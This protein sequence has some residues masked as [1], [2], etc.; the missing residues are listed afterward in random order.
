M[1]ANDAAE[2][3]MSKKEFQF[4]KDNRKYVR[5]KVTRSHN[6]IKANIASCNTDEC[7]VVTE[8][9]NSLRV[10]LNDLNDKV[11]RGLWVGEADRGALDA[12][13]DT[14]DFYDTEIAKA[15]RL[16]NNR[17]CELNPVAAPLSP[18]IIGAPGPNIANQIK[19]PQ[20]PMPEYGN[21]E[22]E[23]LSNFFSNFENVINKY[24][25]SEFEKFVFLS[26][27]LSGHPLTI[28]KSLQSSQQSYTEA[29]NLL[30]KAFEC[31]HNQ[32]YEIIHRLAKIKLEDSGDP[33]SFVSELKIINQ[34]F[35]SLQISPEDILQYFFWYAMPEGLRTQFVHI[36]NNN[37][38]TLQQIDDHIFDAI[39]RYK[40]VKGSR[41]VHKETVSG[42][43]ASVNYKGEHK[44]FK[45]CILCQGSE[46]SVPHAISKCQK[47]ETPKAKTDRL[48]QL[49][50]C[51]KCAMGNHASDDCRFKFYKKCFSCQGQHF[52][53]LCMAGKRDG[54]L[55][56][57]KSRASVSHTSNSKSE[58]SEFVENYSITLNKE[59]LH[60]HSTGSTILPTFTAY[61][62]SG[63]CLRILKDSGSQTSFVRKSL[64]NEEKLKN[65]RKIDL[66]VNGFNTSKQ[67]ETEIVEISMFFGEIKKSFEAVCVPEIKTCLSLPVLKPIVE[68]FISRG[69]ILADKYLKDSDKIDNID[70]ILGANA[71]YCLPEQHFT[72]GKNSIYSKTPL[73][74]LL[75]GDCSDLQRDMV[76]LKD[77]S[78]TKTRSK[79]GKSRKKSKKNKS[80]IKSVDNLNS[81]TS[82]SVSVNHASVIVTDENGLLIE[83]ELSKAANTLISESSSDLLN[84][85]C[86]N[87]LKY[88]NIEH[89]DNINV[90]N[91]ELVESVLDNATRAEDGRL[92]MPLMWNKKL[93]PLL[94]TNLSLSKQILK[95]SLKK[96]STDTTK[97]AMV[98]DVISDQLQQGII[99]KID[100]IDIFISLNPNCSFLAH[101]PIFKLDKETSKC[102]IVYL[103]NICEKKYNSALSV[104]HN[105]A[106]SPGP[107]LNRKISTAVS[108]MRFDE[109][110]LTYDI[111]KA[112]LAIELFPEDA[113]KLC[114]LWYSDVKNKDYSIVAYKMNRLMFGL[115]C[116]PTILM[117]AL[118]KI[119]ILDAHSDD[120][121]I[122]NLK[123]SMY[124]MLYM[125]NGA[126][127]ASS[128]DEL[129]KIFNLL[130]KI[131][132]PYKF[133]LQQFVTNDPVVRKLFTDDDSISE[134]QK[135]LGL[136]WNTS[137]DTFST[138]KLCLNIKADTKRSIL[139]SIASNFDIFN[140]NGPILNRARLFMNTLQVQKNLDWD[141]ILTADQCRSWR[142]IA[143]QVNSS[144]TIHVDRFVG[145]RE[146]Q[147]ELVAFSDSSKLMLGVV[148]YLL[149]NC[150][151]KSHFILAKNRIVGK[152]LENKSI[153][154]LELQALSLATE[155][156]I[157]TYHELCSDKSVMPVNI[158]N[159]RLYSDSLVCLSWLQNHSSKFSKMNKMSPFVM[160]RLNRISKLCETKTVTFGYCAGLMNPADAISRALSYKQLIQTNYVKG[161][162]KES[163][164][165][166]NCGDFPPIVVPSPAIN[167]D[168]SCGNIG[169]KS[170]ECEVPLINRFSRL[171]KLVN[172]VSYV[173]RFVQILKSKIR[174]DNNVNT[175]LT[176]NYLNISALNHLILKEQTI[177]FSD[178]FEYFSD[179]KRSLRDVPLIVTQLNLFRDSEGILRVKAKLKRWKESCL[180]HTYPILLPK[181]SNLTKLIVS[182]FHRNL[183]HSGTYSTL[184]EIRKY[185]WIPQ[186]FSC[187]KK[188]LRDCVL[189]RR[190]NART[191]KLSQSPYRDFR[192]MPANVPFR[193]VFID[194]I[195]PMYIYKENSKVKVYLLL[196]TCLWSRAIDVQIC[197]DL[198][199]REFLRAFQLHVFQYGFPSFCSSDLGSS[200][201]RGTNILADIIKE[202]SVAAYLNEQKIT[203]VEFSQFPKGC[204]ELGGLVESCVKMVKRLFFGAIRNQVLDMDDFA[205]LTAQVN[206]LINKRPIAFKSGL[207]DSDNFEQVPFPITPEILLNGRELA[208]F[209]FVPELNNCD[210]DEISD[211]SWS[212]DNIVS[213]I[214]DSDRKL[215]NVHSFLLKIYNEEFI[216]SLAAQATNTPGRYASVKHDSLE[217]GDIVLLKESNFKPSQYPMGIVQSVTKN[218]LQETT[219]VCLLKGATREVVRRHVS[220]LI[221][222]LKSSEL[223]TGEAAAEDSGPEKE[224][225]WTSI[226]GVRPKRSA[227][228]QSAK[229]TARLVEAGLV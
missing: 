91:D 113:K 102:R 121:Y 72:F 109:K 65:V 88:E 48:K 3:T 187:V 70:I 207:R 152:S 180:E 60:C 194:H 148:V 220:S 138:R 145:T 213:H 111:E 76:H 182:H 13:I 165:K 224:R 147:Y 175:K 97:L 133:K 226:G 222:L 206:C 215:A 15:I 55:P 7:H 17:L 46:Q 142:N 164:D 61:L 197:F 77:L 74:I 81:F 156:L 56:S 151:G 161:L 219:D 195:G 101:M 80:K 174:K 10:K 25:L 105:M 137:L 202:D 50:Y 116:S 200:I 155:I 44:S 229:K 107:T 141:E 4:H 35:D 126:V 143:K 144:P 228:L 38:P 119:L 122:S 16:V 8:N 136:V 169:V 183:F 1:A 87:Y 78:V 42:Y 14:C 172:V 218:C 12:E 223:Q 39:D 149:N 190:Q 178:V 58:T 158:F 84:D 11:S 52:T 128:S 198:S 23:N 171:S 216:P 108:L 104:S 26:R 57:S 66:T 22:G 45:Q 89:S 192:I 170:I 6:D 51:T 19:L 41:Y 9:L 103:S 124:D 75:M 127:G 129:I 193:H 37:K 86:V 131:F 139:S 64:S 157:D 140:F 73:G 132:E 2:V 79:A 167:M 146:D 134:E 176:A 125:D 150:T 227:A 196:F 203:H 159:L 95:S 162:D 217:I 62:P 53:F 94:G 47:Y 163:L 82:M 69:Y 67:Y 123:K 27:Q 115:R 120:S 59:T 204:K 24:S 185:Y 181:A 201:V 34:L 118:Y 99:S 179:K 98:D 210:I 188:I 191:V 28:I 43:A 221:P 54:Y 40:S 30:R 117:L 153:P 205:F 20:L 106:I 21:R 166:L 36:T 209:S 112:F 100:N 32:K 63:K 49:K 29:K 160:N 225:N 5:G 211:P 189:C 83:E 130:P 199:V 18:P 184:N 92:M 212:I 93:S 177:F 208:S 168:L 85:N 90:V 71:L 110:L 96:L 135:L 214:R 68:N 31:P 154:C 33:Y 173:M 186:C 114:F